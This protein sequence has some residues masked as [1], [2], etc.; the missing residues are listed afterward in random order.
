MPD[1]SIV[2]AAWNA[3]GF[4]AQ[5]VSDALAQQGVSLEVIVADDASTDGT[6]SAAVSDERV[7]YVRLPRN[8]GPAAAR[9]AGFA[10]A[11]GEWLMVLDADDR[12]DPGRAAALVGLART[13]K[14]DIVADNF[15]VIAQD[16]SA[17]RLHIAEPL[18]GSFETIDLAMF[19][20]ENQLFQTRPGYGY[21]KPA[22]RREFLVAHGLAYDPALRI[23]ED[24][25][26]V[27]RA[28]AAGARY[29]RHRS[30]G[31]AYVTRAG[32]ISHRLGAADAW[33]MVAAEERF[34]ADAPVQGREMR[35]LLRR[36]LAGLRDGAAFCDMVEAIKAR[37]PGAFLSALARR[38][39]AARHFKMPIMARLRRATAQ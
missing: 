18:D 29:V 5:A 11:R 14:A 10:A 1:V 4:I 19:I 37:R 35:G 32:S 3:E 34:Q 22:F 21:L 23:G 16:G 15:R 38:P 7:R 8:G 28:L 26:L 9:N 12:M 36:R 25:D 6:R 31:Y 17:P 13:E 2:I 33:A 39:L 20:R 24:Y 27:A 30:A